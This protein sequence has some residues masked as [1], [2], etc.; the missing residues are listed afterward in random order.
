MQDDREK[1]LASIRRGLRGL[2]KYS[3]DRSPKSP[4]MI[5]IGSGFESCFAR[6]KS[7]LYALGGEAVVV[8]N[9]TEAAE[10]VSSKMA[11]RT[12][13][14]IYEDI[15][16]NR[17]QFASLISESRQARFGPDFG[18]GYD[19]REA[20]AFDCAVT[21]CVACVAETGTVVIEPDMR[22]PAALATQLFVVAEEEQLL[23]SLDELFTDR[24]SKFE[25]SNLFLITGPSRTADI[26]KELVTGVHGP[27]NVSVIFVQRPK[28]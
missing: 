1:V 12:E 16:S 3:A 10:Y 14:F 23:P 17:Q 21:G 22:L 19:K 27:K 25:G 4:L 24:F 18:K 28:G 20:A 11:K 7:E 9:E 5:K 8:P 15:G 6:F 13:V 2:D 26:E